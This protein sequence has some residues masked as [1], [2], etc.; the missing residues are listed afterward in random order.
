M[1]CGCGGCD[2]QWTQAGG[3]I[4]AL[5]ESMPCKALVQALQGANP[6]VA[7]AN[8][9]K[10]ETL[11][12]QLQ[13]TTLEHMKI[14]DFI[15]NTTTCAPNLV[16]SGAPTEGDE[17]SSLVQQPAADNMSYILPFNL[18][19][20]KTAASCMPAPAMAYASD[21]NILNGGIM[22]GW[23][24]ARAPGFGMAYFDRND[25]DYYYWLADSFTI[26]D[27]YFQ[28]TFTATNP[29]REHLFSGSNGLSVP[30]SGFNMLD[31][32]EPSP[33]FTWETMAE[34]LEGANVTWRVIQEKDNFD[35]NA[36]EWFA[37]FQ[38][39]KPGDWRYEKGVRPVP[40]IVEEFS[41]MVG[42]DT[43]PQVLWIVG[44]AALSEH[45][46]NHPADG[47]DLSARLIS[48]L[49]RAEN[50][51]VY[52]KTAFILNY[53]EGGQ[54]FDHVRP[55]IPPV[56]ASYGKST[57][58]T[59]GELTLT[60]EFGI[61]A[62][63]PIGLG[64][65]VPLFIVSPWTR[66]GY[67]YSQVSDHTSVIQLIEKRFG[68]RC[69]NIS[70]WRRVVAGD[71]TAA[72]NWNDADFSWP[73]GAPSTAANVNQSKW[74]CDHLPA[75][76]LP[77]VQTMPTQ[78][79]GTRRAPPLPY[80]FNITSVVEAPDTTAGSAGNVTLTMTNGGA[81]GAQFYVFNRV[82][83]TARPRTYTIEAGKV[84]SDTWSAGALSQ[85]IYNVSLHGPNGYVYQAAGDVHAAAQSA[86]LSYDEQN[87]RVAVHVS[88]AAPSGPCNFS[89][90]DN[91]YGSGGPWFLVADASS[92][93][94][95]VMDVSDNGNWYD[96]SVELQPLPHCGG[97]YVR[98][99]M[100]HME[101]GAITTTDPAMAVPTQDTAQHPPVPEPYRTPE[102]YTIARDCATR[103]SRMKDH[104]WGLGSEREMIERR[105]AVEL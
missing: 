81:A 29:N 31:D 40:D 98:R 104:C 78:E 52:A 58:D 3:E 22:D 19:F 43:L 25:L 2:I 7:V 63:N 105:S 79:A 16:V 84:L 68:V 93:A 44:P 88:V 69:P 4:K 6:P 45:A 80:R 65:R 48:V 89:V 86:V 66:G 10:C 73:S 41:S 32:S 9:E 70:P 61:P 99:F 21:I 1:L 71:L 96:I 8:G 33:G 100:G 82:A 39:A 50:A 87:N 94:V 97:A 91:A 67:V 53:D 27:Q 101:T 28:S 60:E 95:H 57:V 11:L 74:Q 37:T 13:N 38:D 62:G 51:E 30:N 5:V 92:P 90:T 35:D 85:S 59:T 56:N 75:P 64:F 17:A 26:G 15:K 23:N 77:A 76:T 14:S 20:N 49:G 12:T 72:F 46:E 42:N 103:R 83:P 34:T 54:F 55:P 18:Q 102:K 24:T 47:E 36:F